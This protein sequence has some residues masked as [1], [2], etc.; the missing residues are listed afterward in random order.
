MIR[1]D[2]VFWLGKHFRETFALPEDAVEWLLDLW[3]VIQVFDDIADGDP[4]DRDDLNRAILGCLVRM[5]QNGFYL[6]HAHLLL[7]QIHTAILKWKASD[8]VEKDFDPCA[9]SFVWRAGYYDIVLAVVSYVHD[10]SIAMEIGK[11][12]LKLYGESLE[13]YM[14]EFSNA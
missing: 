2:V 6:R 10:E 1:E 14:E 13:D 9:T 3:N 5:P 12:V 11:S 4:V 8:D 7:P